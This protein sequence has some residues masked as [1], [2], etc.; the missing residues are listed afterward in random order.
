[1]DASAWFATYGD[2]GM[3]GARGQRLSQAV[4]GAMNE[5]AFGQRWIALE[6]ADWFDTSPTGGGTACRTG[7][8]GEASEG[9]EVSGGLSGFA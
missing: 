4:Q 1:M 2:A 3:R 8:M 6:L 9:F 5:L 7:D